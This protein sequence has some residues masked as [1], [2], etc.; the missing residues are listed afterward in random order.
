MS[1][2]GAGD[3]LEWVEDAPAAAAPV[4][5]GP[6]WDITTAAP[7][8]PAPA[9]AMKKS[10]DEFLSGVT[11]EMLDAS[12]KFKAPAAGVNYMLE[13]LTPEQAYATA[14]GLVDRGAWSDDNRLG[15]P[16][17]QQQ[18]DALLDTSWRTGPNNGGGFLGGLGNAAQGMFDGIRTN[19][20]MMAFATAGLAPYMNQ[21]IQALGASA[22]MAKT[23]TPLA[24]NAGSTIVKGG[25]AADALKGAGL[26]YLGGEAIKTDALSDLPEA[27]KGGI[28]GLIASG[29]DLKK[30]VPSL[31]MSLLPKGSAAPA[32]G[33]EYTPRTS[34]PEDV[35]V[36]PEYLA[37]KRA[38][39]NAE[40]AYRDFDAPEMAQYALPPVDLG[41][42]VPADATPRDV[43]D[44]R[45]EVELERR[46]IT[47]KRAPDEY[48][49]FEAPEMD[50]VTLSPVDLGLGPPAAPKKTDVKAPA[51]KDAFAKI[52]GM[53][54]KN[55]S[56]VPPSTGVDTSGASG[57]GASGA[58]VG[59]GAYQ[60]ANVKP[61]DGYAKRQR[62]NAK[63]QLLEDDDN[64]KLTP[65]VTVADRDETK[66]NGPELSALGL[67]PA[68]TMAAL[69]GI[70]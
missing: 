29:G 66:E 1:W 14:Q 67:P 19:P 63:G 6:W 36:S 40:S 62:L 48:S 32:D 45:G 60:L 50:R 34:W 25:N 35:E 65:D 21:G 7:S 13:G 70:T 49:Q 23:L 11:P 22:N 10:K 38:A 56:K 68:D 58:G 4:Q 64:N 61:F 41:A 46:T 42:D 57:T 59:A 15:A 54:P 28:K 27:A 20:A 37:S 51:T 43:L 39:V 44:T 26:A 17:A 8:G 3:N 12:G 2:R 69:F 55:A 24:M 30:A 16:M 5:Q 53:L 47:G 52:V 18:A 33:N 31:A 9:L